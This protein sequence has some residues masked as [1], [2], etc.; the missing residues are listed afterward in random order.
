[1]AEEFAPVKSRPDMKLQ[2]LARSI[3]RAGE[4]AERIANSAEETAALFDSDYKSTSEWGL[5]PRV[6]EGWPVYPEH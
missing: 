6:E 1:M 3:A 4:L 5:D 2:R